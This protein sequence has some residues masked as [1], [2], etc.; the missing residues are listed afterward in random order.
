MT[1]VTSIERRAIERGLQQGRE[2]GRE[3][4][5]LRRLRRAIQ[6]RFQAIPTDLEIQLA[7]LE[8]E[9]VLDALNDVAL[10]ASSL[11]E[12]RRTFSKITAS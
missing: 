4:A 8:D 1:Y 3:E 11:E 12:F 9:A 6:V 2:E 7:E 10:L 5:L